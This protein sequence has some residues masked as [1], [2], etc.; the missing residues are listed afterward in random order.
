MYSFE[1]NFF[2]NPVLQ[3]DGAR[4]FDNIFYGFIGALRRNGQIVGELDNI[5]EQHD[6]EDGN[7]R[8]QLRCIAPEQ[9]SLDAKYHSVYA[10]A[11][12]VTLLEMSTQPPQY[13]L[14]AEIFDK[15]KCCSCDAPSFYILFTTHLATASSPVDCG[16]CKLPVPLYRLPFVFDEQEH[17]AILSWQATYQAC[18]TL[19]MQSGAGERFGLRQMTRL[20]SGLS[21]SGR[22]ICAAMASK[23]GRPF[24]YYLM[25][26]KTEKE[27]CPDCGG[28]WKLET[29]SHEF[30]QFRCNNCF[31]LSNNK[32]P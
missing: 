2:P 10:R 31:L 25:Q 13:R 21:L 8:I 5:V 11:E 15:R 16:D 22:E 24:Y 6:L 20:D 12:F 28:E 29:A 27:L 26:N 19:Y 1:L 14:V 18:D 23:K 7:K 30:Y 4:G 17:Y 3:D 32:F 9:D